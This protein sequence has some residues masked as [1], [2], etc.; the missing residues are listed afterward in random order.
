MGSVIYST[1]LRPGTRRPECGIR[2]G[3][4]GVA[5]G[6][7]G[8]EGAGW[9]GGC[10]LVNRDGETVG[11]EKLL[12]EYRKRKMGKTIWEHPQGV[13]VR[14]VGRDQPT[15]GHQ[16]THHLHVERISNRYIANEEARLCANTS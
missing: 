8:G 5:E 4:G 11:D 10:Y 16:I 6:V 2:R 1:R 7:G 14:V 12:E 13:F 3:R 9:E 15:E